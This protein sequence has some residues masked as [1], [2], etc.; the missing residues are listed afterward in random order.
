LGSR[1]KLE[2]TKPIVQPLPGTD[3]FQSRPEPGK[4]AMRMSPP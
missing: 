4:S 1:P 2:F 3:S